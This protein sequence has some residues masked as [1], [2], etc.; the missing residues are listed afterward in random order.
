[1]NKGKNCK[2]CRK[3]KYLEY[4]YP[5]KLGKFGR[6][7]SCI[8]CTKQSQLLWRQN[9]KELKKA[10]DSA[11]RIANAEKVRIYKKSWA[12]R[13]PDKIYQSQKTW[14]DKNP[15][16][17]LEYGIKHRKRRD[18]LVRQHTP[19]WVDQSEILKIY[20]DCRSMTRKTGIVHHVDHIIPLKGKNVCGLHCPANLQIIPAIDN[21]RKSNK[22]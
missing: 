13:N 20:R 16:K 7:A 1:M 2:K 15:S 8:A 14:R 5:K 18:R 11:Y 22:C 17:T 9:N 6:E 3:Y 12:D 4:F 10:M 19:K 21:L